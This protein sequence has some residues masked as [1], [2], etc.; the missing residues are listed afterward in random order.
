MLWKEWNTLIWNI[1][2]IN[3]WIINIF[4]NEKINNMHKDNNF[5]PRLLNGRENY[6]LLPNFF[7]HN[8]FCEW[9]I[10]KRYKIIKK[11]FTFSNKNISSNSQRLSYGNKSTRIPWIFIKPI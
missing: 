1:L 9:I 3:E 11:I 7:K 4:H 10:E 2:C 8:M 5:L 6:V